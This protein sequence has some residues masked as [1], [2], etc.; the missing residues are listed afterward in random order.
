MPVGPSTKS[1]DAAA[2]GQA[3][4]RSLGGSSITTAGASWPELVRHVRLGVVIIGLV[5][6]AAILRLWNLGDRALHHDESLDAWYSWRFLNGT[7]E[8]YDPVYHGPLRFYITSAF[9]WLF[10]ESDATARLLSAL[11]GIGSVAFVWSLRRELGRVGTI[12]AAAA[13]CL[14]PTM[15][16]YSRFGREDAQMVFLALAAVVLAIGYLRAPRTSVAVG[17]MFVL[18]CSFAIKESTYLFCLLLALYALVVVASEFDA[19]RRCERD[20][21][22]DPTQLDPAFFSSM[23]LLASGGLLASVV[24]GDRSDQLFLVITVYGLAL[25][26]CVYVIGFV[27]RN[28]AQITLPPALNAACAIGIRGWMVAF[29]V[30]VITWLALFTVFGQRPGDWASG[31]VDAIGYWDSQQEVN[32]GGQ[33]WYYYLFALPAYEWLFVILAVV[34]GGRVLKRPTVATGSLVWLAV[35]SL[36]LYS[37]AGERMPWLIAHP[38]LP[39]LLLAG[40]GGQALW[41]HREHRFATPIATALAV[42][43]LFTTITSLETSFKRPTDS[44]EILS[45]AGQATPH[46]KA[47]LQ[48][49]ENIDKLKRHETGQPALLAIQTTNAWP[50]SWHLRERSHVVWFN[51][52]DGPPTDPAPDIIIGDYGTIDPANFPNY[53]PTLFAMRSWWTVT[54]TEAG[55]LGWLRWMWDR[56]LWPQFYSSYNFGAEIEASPDRNAVETIRA[57]RDGVD[58]AAQDWIDSSFG[59]STSKP[60]LHPDNQADND[61][62]RDGCGSIDQWFLVH[63]DWAAREKQVYR[64][65]IESMGT[66]A[67][68]ND[69]LSTP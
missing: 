35:G 27:R 11:C 28:E 49:V 53:T 44:R 54:Y 46:V 31:F 26:S 2:V 13:L 34:G 1:E 39:I 38:L 68:A 17:L 55:P 48:R 41:D 19:Q 43:V 65:A 59:A 29:G 50:W 61:D 20:P 33:P 45:Q 51:A 3:E 42:A 23:L 66:L 16:Y 15:L 12:V 56:T 18:A 22:R 36:I 67:C 4:S 10:G 6:L 62:G 5:G 60:P 40:I 7:F 47:A 8:G 14:S 32:R 37:Y 25:L 9:F 69:L 63:N 30:F 24:V 21:A 58:R 64:G 57:L 52:E